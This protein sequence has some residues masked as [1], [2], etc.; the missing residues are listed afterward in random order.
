MAS[1][2]MFAEAKPRVALMLVT[3]GVIEAL[4]V[5]ADPILLRQLDDPDIPILALHVCNALPIR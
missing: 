2:I 4:I 1:P 3:G 5:A